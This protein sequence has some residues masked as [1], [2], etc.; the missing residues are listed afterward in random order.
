L[1]EV[2]KLCHSKVPEMQLLKDHIDHMLPPKRRQKCSNMPWN[3]CVARPVF[4]DEIRGSPGTQ[5]ALRKEWDRLR[6]IN[7]W[8]EDQV[9]ECCEVK[10]RAKRTDTKIHM[11]MV[12]QICV[13]K[14]AE[15]EK[16]EWLRKWKGRVI[17][18]GNDVVG[19]N[20]DVAMFQE[21]GSAPATMVATKMCD[22]CGLIRNHTNENA[23]ATQAYTQSLVG[24]TKTWV[25][26]PR[27]EWPES[28][29]HMRRLVCPLE[30]ALR[31]HP[32]SGG[33]WEQHC[34]NH[35]EDCGF[36]P[37]VPD[38]RAWRSCYFR[39]TLKCYMIVY[40]DDFKITGPQDGVTEAWR[41]IRGP[42]PRAGERGIILD[43][44][45]KARKCLGCNREC[46][47]VWAPPTHADTESVQPLEGV[48][49]SDVATGVQYS[50]IIPGSEENTQGVTPPVAY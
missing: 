17:F 13:E 15:T 1:R 8:R 28:W 37:V 21:L 24:G 4:K 47:H 48:Q 33:Y 10:A 50:A 34:D 38:D 49:N 36:G 42:N 5:A 27:E 43:D 41:L 16:E 9:E 30:K 39:S 19:E 44:P 40:V 35:V 23:D 14:D 20:W 31:G 29:K 3:C 26:L 22:V 6:L 18:R 46:S 45:T 12:F 11:G 25:S 2:C 7:T 32:D